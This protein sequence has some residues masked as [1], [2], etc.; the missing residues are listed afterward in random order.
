MCDWTRIE[1]FIGSG[2]FLFYFA[3]YNRCVSVFSY[4][5]YPGA[6]WFMEWL[7]N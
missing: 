5:I 7:V 1:I 2:F 3:Q 4:Y 6:V